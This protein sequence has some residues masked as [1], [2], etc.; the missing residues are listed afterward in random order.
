MYEYPS[1]PVGWVDPLGLYE[2]VLG[3]SPFNEQLAY[4]L[5]Q[6]KINAFP[7]SL[8]YQKG[9]A[10]KPIDAS[11]F[12]SQF[13]E[14]IKKAE[15]IHFSLAGLD[16]EQVKNSGLNFDVKNGLLQSGNVTNVELNKILNDKSL[17]AKTNF[18]KIKPDGLFIEVSHS[19]VK[20][21]FSCKKN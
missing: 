3:R 15:R 8:W 11:T 2:I 6:A 19:I 17:M 9:I 21:V 14:V 4:D 16:P 12:V 18:Y 10:S 7:D 13:D 5:N 1:D 20:D